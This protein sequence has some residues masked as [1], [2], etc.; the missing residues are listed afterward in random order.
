MVLDEARGLGVVAYLATLTPTKTQP[1]T[2]GTAPIVT[3][4]SVVPVGQPVTLSLQSGLSLSGARIVWE[5]RDQEPAF[6]STFTFTP[7]NNGTQWVEAEAQWPDGRRVFTTANFTANSP[8]VVWV[9]D[10]V[11]AGGAPGASGGN[12]WIWTSDS[13]PARSGNR[14]HKSANAAGMHERW[15]DNATATLAIGHGDTLYAYVYLDPA[16]PPT[17]IMLAWNNGTWEHRAYWGAN[18][19]TYGLSGTESR[20]YLGPLPAVGQWIRLEVP[21]S[22]VG[23]EGS[24]LKG[25]DFVAHGGGVTWD[26]AGKTS[27]VSSPVPANS[28]ASSL[29]RVSGGAMQF[30]WPGAVGKFY[31]V[32]YKNNLTDAA[33]TDLSGD[34]N[35]TGTPCSWTDSTASSAS[36]RFYLVYAVN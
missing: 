21:A 22:Q 6:G 12:S 29:S 1:W 26:C 30:N 36:K 7:R 10:A 33:W 23:L 27:M 20:R 15:F 17:E 13:P 31:R 8:N 3:P 18:T 25:M 28:V 11:P 5:G 19:I 34:I 4:A 16:T 35:G 24:I 9:D 2:S 14:A 32:A